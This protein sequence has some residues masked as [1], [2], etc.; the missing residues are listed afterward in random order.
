MKDVRPTGRYLKDLKL[1]QRRG[2]D[3]K[4]L[5]AVLDLLRAGKPLPASNRD[6][7]LKGRWQNYRDCHIAPDW[8]L[9]YRDRGHEIELVRTGT[10][11]DLF[12]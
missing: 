4:K 6:H 8:V 10:H 2:Y 3:L 9:I 11:S 5:E 7:A 1:T 12:G